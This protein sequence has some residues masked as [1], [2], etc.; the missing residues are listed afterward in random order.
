MT[1][2]L[3]FPMPYGVTVEG[4]GVNRTAQVIVGNRHVVRD[5]FVRLPDGPC[6]VAASWDGPQSVRLVHAG[7]G[8]PVVIP[9]GGGVSLWDGHDWRD[10]GGGALLGKH[11]QCSFGEARPRHYRGVSNPHLAPARVVV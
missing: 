9:A 11:G 5:S 2:A 1:T 10:C 6:R 3:D 7:H 4:D 8:Y